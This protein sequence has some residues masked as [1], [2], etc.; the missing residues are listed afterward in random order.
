M[1]AHLDPLPDVV[2]VDEVQFLDEGLLPLVERLAQRGVRVILAGL[3]L[4]FRGEPFGLMPELL[5]RAEFVE[6]LT[7]ICPRCGAPAT[8]DPALGERPT[9]PLHRPRD[10]GGSGGALRAPVPGLPP[11]ALLSHGEGGA[12]ALPEAH[13][14]HSVA[15]AR[16]GRALFDGPR[17]VQ[18]AAE[19]AHGPLLQEVGSG[20]G[21]AHPRQ[22]HAA[23]LLQK[24]Q[25]LGPN[26]RE[27]HQ[28]DVVVLVF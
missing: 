27:I 3:D 2:A 5:A 20:K 26:S 18:G 23:S 12:R 17:Q 13:L 6:K 15:Q 19:G 28:E 9:G 8:P 10:P 4:D 7:A 24:L 11:S 21:M 14:Q 22:G 25:V 1:E 16:L